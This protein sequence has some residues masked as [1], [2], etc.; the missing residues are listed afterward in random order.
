MPLGVDV[1]LGPGHIVLDGDPALPPPKKRDTDPQFSAHV[2]CGQTAGCI[3][4]PL[5]REV[6]LAPGGIVFLIATFFVGATLHC[7]DKVEHGCRTIDLPLSSSIKIV[8]TFKRLDI[9]FICTIS[10]FQKHDRQN[11]K[12]VKLF[13]VGAGGEVPYGCTRHGDRGSCTSKPLH[14]WRFC[15]LLRGTENLCKN[16]TPNKHLKQMP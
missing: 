14:I 10:T 6:G 3:K 11:N 1:G 7:R 16:A 8:S 15:L 2:C 13:R 9:E 5:S 4:M 12:N